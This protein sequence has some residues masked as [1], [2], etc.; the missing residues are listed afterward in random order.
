MVGPPIHPTLRQVLHQYGPAAGM[1]PGQAVILAPK[2][3]GCSRP[4]VHVELSSKRKLLGRLTQEE[5]YKLNG[6][7]SAD[8]THECQ[9]STQPMKTYI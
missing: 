2:T 5:E 3:G 8:V 6:G 4:P 9:L 7:N 1:V